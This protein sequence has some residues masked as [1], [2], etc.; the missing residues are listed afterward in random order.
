M[1]HTWY[2]TTQFYVMEKYNLCNY[3][4][5]EVCIKKGFTRDKCIKK[6]SVAVG[7]DID[8]KHKDMTTKIIYQSLIQGENTKM[9]LS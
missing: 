7:E 1:D 4:F 3:R 5:L 8:V 9:F 6:G 2:S